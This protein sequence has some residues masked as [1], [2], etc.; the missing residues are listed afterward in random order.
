[1]NGKILNLGQDPSLNPFLHIAEFLSGVPYFYNKL[2]KVKYFKN[3]KKIDKYFSSSVRHLNL[4]IKWKKDKINSLKNQ[5]IKDKV[6]KTE[7][8]G[9]GKIYLIKA[10]QYTKT[11]L[12]LLSKN[13]FSFIKLPRFK[14][15][16][17][18]YK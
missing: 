4:N 15:N 13:Q 1:M 9:D 17:I 5:L 2:T 8:L 7:N 14:K 11:A 3:N 6:F 16:I 10:K 12:R 18:P